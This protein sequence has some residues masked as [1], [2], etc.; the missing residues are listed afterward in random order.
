MK[1]TSFIA[2][3]LLLASINF[4]VRFIGFIYKILLSRLIGPQAIGL[5]QMIIPFL[6]VLIVL[7]TAG[8]PIAVSKLVARENSLKN[9]I[10]VYKL[11]TISLL[12]GGTIALCLSVFVSLQLDYIVNNL[13]KNQLL[14]YPLLWGIPALAVI[15]FSSILRGFFYGLKDIRPAAAA[16]ILEQLARVF[17]VLFFLYYKKPSHPVTAV[18][19]AI[20]G[21]VIGE[22]V[23]LFYLVIRLNLKKISSINLVS[24]SNVSYSNYLK[25]I[26]SISVPIT[27][28]K[29]ISVSMQTINAIIIPHRLILAGFSPIIATEIYGKVFGMAMPMLF[30]PFTVTSALVLNLIPNISEHMA[31]NN[32]ANIADKSSLA[33]KITLLVAIPITMIYI[34]FGN[35]IGYIVFRQSD[36]GNYL[37]IIG[38]AT[39]FL[40]IQH[41]FSGI[42]HGIGKQVSVSI[43]YVIGMSTQ[44]YFTYFLVSNPAYGINGFFVGFIASSFVILTLHSIIIFRTIKIKLPFVTSILKPTISSIVMLVGIYLFNQYASQFIPNTFILAALSAVCA[45]LIYCLMLVITNVLNIKQIIRSLK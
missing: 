8:I 14:Y 15:T 22:A 34:V 27:I 4:I 10:G 30:L 37:S 45:A 6:M 31:T 19:I 7:P 32:H 40:C 35:T 25:Q 3:T 1:K 11:L 17:F 39:L 28:S 38:V 36:V 9:T 16:Q 24:S 5:Y 18:T 42:L 20:I 12:L 26:S 41:T 29:F 33:I 2:G 13:L 43:N 21:I 44:L 23:G